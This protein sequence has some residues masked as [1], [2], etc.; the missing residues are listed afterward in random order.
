MLLL[1]QLQYSPCFMYANKKGQVG[2]QNFVRMIHKCQQ[3]QLQTIPHTDR[4][5]YHI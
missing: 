2:N 1:Q 4:R 5:Q 3:N